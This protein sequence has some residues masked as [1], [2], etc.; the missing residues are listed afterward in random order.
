MTQLAIREP[1]MPDQQA[2]PETLSIILVVE[3]RTCENCGTTHTV[4]NP[5]LTARIEDPRY[6]SRPTRLV[7]LTSEVYTKHTTPCER[8]DIHTSS[9]VCHKC[10]ASYTPDNQGEL[11]PREEREMPRERRGPVDAPDKPRIKPLELSEF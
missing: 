1:T 11:W 8:T 10:F 6:A 5:F 3:H 2:I 7:K 4:P 9:Q